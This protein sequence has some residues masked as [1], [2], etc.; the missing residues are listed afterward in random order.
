MGKL[1]G[2]IELGGTKVVAAVAT[3]PVAPLLRTC[4]PTAD[5][6]STLNAVAAF[7]EAASEQFGLPTTL[8]IASFGPID[9]RPRSRDWGRIG[10]TSKAGWEGA[11]VAAHPRDRLNCR[12]KLD[13]DVNGAALAEARWGAG[14]DLGD[15]AYLTIGTGIG[16]GLI[17]RRRPV[18]GAMHPEI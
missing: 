8:G 14:R 4:I 18:H 16:G 7:F 6:A 12:V 1:L 9:I 17:V 13:T 3:D 10:K 2:S 5:P 15:I 11:N